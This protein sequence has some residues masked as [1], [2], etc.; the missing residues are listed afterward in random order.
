MHVADE[1]GNRYMCKPLLE[2]LECGLG[3][4]IAT[5]R[6]TSV[7]RQA[8]V[9]T[10]TGGIAGQVSTLWSDRKTSHFRWIAPG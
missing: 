10:L 6:Q 7:H 1:L 3:V 5:E 9:Y 4:M 8:G 2:G